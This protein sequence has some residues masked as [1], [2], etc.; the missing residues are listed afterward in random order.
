MTFQEYWKIKNFE[1]K[2]MRLLGFKPRRY[3]QVFH[4]VKKSMFLYP[5]EKQT[6]GSGQCIDALIKEMIKEDKIAIVKLNP[7]GF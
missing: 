6:A 1:P 5:N 7:F 2:G 4:N 3:L